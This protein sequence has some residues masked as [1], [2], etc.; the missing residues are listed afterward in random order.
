MLWEGAYIFM[1]ICTAYSSW[2]MLT[3]PIAVNNT[4]ERAVALKYFLSVRAFYLANSFWLTL[5][6][7]H[8]LSPKGR[9][10]EESLIIF[11]A[12][13]IIPAKRLI[14]DVPQWRPTPPSQWSKQERKSAA[15]QNM[16]ALSHDLG[17]WLWLWILGYY[18][19]RSITHINRM[20]DFTILHVLSL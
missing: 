8:R 1:W 5:P 2:F 13:S 16:Y 10:L 3:E 19:I 18:G 12:H 7:S 6:L 15:V 14:H 9:L 4:N 20:E 11:T 17:F